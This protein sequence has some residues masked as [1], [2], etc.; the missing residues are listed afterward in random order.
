MNS[1]RHV[2][3]LL[4]FLGL[5]GA[6][7]FGSDPTLSQDSGGASVGALSLS[8]AAPSGADGPGLF[9][10]G[11]GSLASA[12]MASFGRVRWKSELPGPRAS[13]LG[14]LRSL[15][16]REVRGLR[17]TGRASRR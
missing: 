7:W 13:A 11:E 12:D 1:L 14:D 6:V 17:S 4:L 3:C 15:M 5:I 8:V 10:A 2:L 16:R 9:A